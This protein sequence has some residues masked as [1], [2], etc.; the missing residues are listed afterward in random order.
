MATSCVASTPSPA[1]TPA[2]KDQ[3][4]FPDKEFDF[5]ERPS[6]DFFCPVSLEL[7]LEPQLTSCCGHHL[8]LEVANRLQKEGKPCPVCN[9]ESWSAMLD[10][11]HGRRVREVRVR[12]WNKDSGC[13]WVGEVNEL[14]RHAVSCEKRPWECEYCGLK[15]TYDEGEGKHWPE[16]PKFPEPCP[17][18]CEV[19]SVERCGMEQHLSVCPLEPVACEMKEFGC[20][21]VVP[22]RELATHMRES[23][24]QHLTAMTALNLRLTR[25]LQQE[26]EQLQKDSAER[27]RKIVQLQQDSAERD[28]KIQE[29]LKALNAVVKEEV[30][31][32][33]QHI[34][35]H[36]LCSG[37]KVLEFRNYRSNKEKAKGRQVDS[38]SDKFYSHN[39]GYAF[40][41]RI[42][43]YGDYNDIGAFLC[44]VEG[45]NDDQLSWPV[46]I[47]VTLEL[48]NQA[49]N[50]NHLQRCK[51]RAWAEGERAEMAIDNSLIK[52]AILEKTEDNLK[53]LLNDRLKFRIS[54]SVQ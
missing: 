32:C 46:K 9:S 21:V 19:G 41:L 11:Y 27:D 6:Q 31:S 16:C 47:F 4:L 43:Y 14:K 24:L 48:L 52:Y 29:E 35:T 5:V 53:Y 1:V 17:N 22:R 23:G 30:K 3:P 37:C 50:N 38:F 25:Q 15:C 40:K 36:T 7:L 12:C 26:L 42:R 10:K 28:R 39:G 13:G 18:G 49:G 8:S 51:A 34:D 20:S 33:V 2:K 44:L 45:E 54:V